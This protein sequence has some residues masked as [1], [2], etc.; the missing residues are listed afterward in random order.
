MGQININ[1][2]RNK[3]DILKEL[4]CDKVDILMVSETKLDSSFPDAQ[5]LINGYSKP[6]RLDRNGK[7]GGIML[8]LRNDI[9]SKCLNKSEIGCK[10]YLLIEMNL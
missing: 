6:Y 7:G 9:P 5:F 1:S 8:Y 4:I 10:E 2:I 3:F